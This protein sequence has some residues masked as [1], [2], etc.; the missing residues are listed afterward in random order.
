MV[1][2]AGA[3]YRLSL[4][5]HDL[6][7][8]GEPASGQDGVEPCH[9]DR[10]LGR[11]AGRVLAFVPVVVGPGRRAEGLVLGLV[12]GVVVAERDQR[13]R[14][15]RDRVGA[16]RQGLGDVGTVADAAR[17]DEL[18]LAVHAELL[19]GLDGRADAGQRRHADILDEDLLGGG[20]AALH[21]VH[22][23][24][25][26]AGF[27]GERH[28]VIGPGAADLHVDRLLPVGDLAQLGDLDLEIVRAGP[29]GV[30]GRRT[31]VD[32]LR[33]RA[34]LGHAIGD[35]LP[36]QHAAPAGLGALADDDLDGVGLAQIVRVHAVARGKVL[37]DQ[38]LRLA[39][40]LARHAAVARGG[41]GAG[42]RGPAPERLL[43]MGRQGAEAH[44]RDG[45]GD[46]EV[47]RLFGKARAQHDIGAAT[48]PVAFQ[49]ISRHGG[50]EKQKV[51]EMRQPALRPAA[52]DVVDAGRGGAADFRHRIVVERR[53]FPRRGRRI[54]I[55]HGAGSLC[56]RVQRRR[57]RLTVSVG[58]V[59]V[60]VVELA[61]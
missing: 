4:Q 20:R 16:K 23:H 56:W 37:V 58:M 30:A 49:R 14:A 33:Q 8:I 13:R 31:L 51:V 53:G 12:D 44:A 47:D 28:V 32:A 48:L 52:P 35:L 10:V 59:D 36:E 19:Q 3:G 18:H 57:K 38:R 27:D 26:G 11:D 55:R 29:I 43:G 5:R 7:V 45:D 42:R 25:I 50:A 61:L 2:A 60:E 24:D 46:L 40:L 22:H 41:R 9:Q 6:Q 21:A 15:D 54:V 17:N 1:L 34:H 39:A